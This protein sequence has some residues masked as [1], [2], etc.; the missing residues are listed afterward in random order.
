MAEYI[1]RQIDTSTYAHAVAYLRMQCPSNLLLIF[2]YFACF[3]LSSK[4]INIVQ[5]SVYDS[6][7]VFINT[8]L[9]Q[10]AYWASRSSPFQ[11]F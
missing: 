2:A 1:D 6:G 11:N 3:K 8:K 10:C 9:S 5:H 4:C 7:V